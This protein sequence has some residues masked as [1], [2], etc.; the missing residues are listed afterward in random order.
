M[1]VG[2]GKVVGVISRFMLYAYYPGIS[3]VR[4]VKVPF[5]LSA[6][7]KLQCKLSISKQPQYLIAAMSTLRIELDHRPVC[8]P[9]EVLSGRVVLH[10]VTDR[11]IG[12]VSINL[13]GR[14]KTKIV[15]HHGQSSSYYRG[16]AVFFDTCQVLFQGHHTHKSDTYS[17]PF[18]L[19]LPDHPTTAVGQGKRKWQM[20]AVFLSTDIGHD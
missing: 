16:R 11:A 3:K 17:S 1:Y 2:I 15:R 4:K 19:T 12:Q 8:R 13:F 9:G 6:R 20:S 14:A 18:S 7:T 5:S 10:T